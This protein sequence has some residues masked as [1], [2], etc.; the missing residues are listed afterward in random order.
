MQHHIVEDESAKSSDQILKDLPVAD[1][2]AQQAFGGAFARNPFDDNNH[3][4]HVAGTIGAI[5]N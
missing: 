2:Q 1:E 3:G 4:T 5:G